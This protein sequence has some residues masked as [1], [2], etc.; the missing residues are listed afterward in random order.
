M[1]AAVQPDLWSQSAESRRALDIRM[2]VPLATE[3]ANR[4]GLVGLTVA[5]MFTDRDI[6]AFD[7]R[8]MPQED[9]CWLTAGQDGKPCPRDRYADFYLPDAGRWSGHRL[10]ATLAFGTIPDGMVVCHT[11]DVRGCV[12]PCHLFVGTQSDNIQ[13]AANKGRLWQQQQVITHCKRGHEFTFENTIFLKTGGRNCRECT[14]RLNREKVRRYLQR[15]N[16]DP[17]KRAARLEKR[18]ERYA[19][20][21]RDIERLTPLAAELAERAGERGITISDL[22]IAAENRGLLTGEEQGRRLSFL[23][24]VMQR[25]GLAKNGRYRRSDVPRSHGNLHAEWVSPEYAR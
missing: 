14:R 23:G 4:V 1:S 9:G 11:C 10:A 2:L 15:V 5:E 19:I 6:A 7:A 18:R 21:S 25:A 8:I 22:R 20:E 12:N 24:Q 3:L 13:D 16:A 17:V